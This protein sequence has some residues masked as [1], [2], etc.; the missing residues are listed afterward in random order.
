MS[1]TRHNALWTATLT[2]GVL[3]LSSARAVAEEAS[4]GDAD[5]QGSDSD[6]VIAVDLDGGFGLQEE[7]V[8]TGYGG[9]LRLGWRTNPLWVFAFSPE[10]AGH[11]FSFGGDR[12]PV[13]Y[14]GMAGLRLGFDFLIKIGAFA[15]V[16]AGRLEPAGEGASAYTA[17]AWDAG[18]LLGF[19]LIPTLLDF[20]LHFS[21]N[22][23]AGSDG[24][25]RFDFG[26]A[27]VHLELKL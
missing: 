23:V 3:M 5:K 15:H 27:G 19:T 6:L 26:T 7:D 20:G 22:A 14:R 2:A 16:G 4:K 13:I 10:V 12:G 21:A 24:G 17:L 8:D 9:G 11:A 18:V 1:R 25:P